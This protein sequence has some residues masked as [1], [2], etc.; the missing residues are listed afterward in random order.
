MHSP[1]TKTIFYLSKGNTAERTDAV[2]F[3]AWNLIIPNV[4]YLKQDIF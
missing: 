4:S 3:D 2:D 1:G